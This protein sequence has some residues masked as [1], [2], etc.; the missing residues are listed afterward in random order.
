MW[1]AYKNHSDDPK[2]N[3]EAAFAVLFPGQS[4]DPGE[5]S[6]DDSREPADDPAKDSDSSDVDEEARYI[7]EIGLQRGESEGNNVDGVGYIVSQTLIC[8]IQVKGKFD[9]PSEE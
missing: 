8:T 2:Y 5:D 3:A 7:S 1:A 4:Y 6:D 9:S